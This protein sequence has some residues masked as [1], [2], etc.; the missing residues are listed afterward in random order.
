MNRREFLEALASIPLLGLLVK[1]PKLQ[2]PTPVRTIRDAI[3]EI[4][5][6]QGWS[7]GSLTYFNDESEYIGNLGRE[8]GLAARRTLE[9]YICGVMEN[10][11]EGQPSWS[12]IVDGI[13]LSEHMDSW[14]GKT[15]FVDLVAGDDDNDGLTPETA[16]TW[17]GW[18][19][20][21]ESREGGMII[22]SYPEE[23]A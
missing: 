10:D 16:V 19:P 21:V 15:I 2:A 1:L 7:K 3:T 20:L 9:K 8:M 5:D 14:N 23:Q 13:D 22:C 4:V 17:E 12:I 6:R 18:L 11:E